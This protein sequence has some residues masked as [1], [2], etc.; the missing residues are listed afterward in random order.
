MENGR[1]RNRRG[2]HYKKPLLHDP[3]AIRLR[4]LAAMLLLG[5]LMIFGLAAAAML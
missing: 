2:R 4:E 5:G 1:V 3:W